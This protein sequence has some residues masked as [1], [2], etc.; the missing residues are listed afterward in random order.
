MG[1]EYGSLNLDMTRDILRI[2]GNEWGLVG[3][4]GKDNREAQ[5]CA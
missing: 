4:G 2:E 5:A 1:K 3:E